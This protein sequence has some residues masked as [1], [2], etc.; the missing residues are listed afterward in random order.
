MNSRLEQF[1]NDVEVRLTA[2]KP[3]VREQEIAEIRQHLLAIAA[4]EEALGASEVEAAETAIRQF[5]VAGEVA[6]ELN[7]TGRRS[8]LKRLPETAVTALCA[9]TA[10]PFIG[11]AVRTL[12]PPPQL[13]THAPEVSHLPGPFCWLLS[14]VAAAV[15]ILRDGGP[16]TV[17]RLT[18]LRTPSGVA[19]WWLFALQCLGALS[20]AIVVPFLPQLIVNDIPRIL[21]FCAIA[22]FCSVVLPAAGLGWIAERLAPR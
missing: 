6:T 1:V 22:N 14:I 19:V 17:Q 21:F 5:G 2:L 20:N 7:A 3:E 10:T 18:S 11:L 15:L 9:L 12:I 13:G 8:R 4:A 16:A